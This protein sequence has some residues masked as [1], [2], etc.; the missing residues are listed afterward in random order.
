MTEKKKPEA[1]K[2]S[3]SQRFSDVAKEHGIE[4]KTLLA[5]V[6]QFVTAHPDFQDIVY[7]EGKKPS[8]S[9]NLA[10]TYRKEFFDFIEDKVPKKAV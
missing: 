5:L 8:P 1:K 4:V 9:S 2:P 10:K 7:V 3:A 6:D